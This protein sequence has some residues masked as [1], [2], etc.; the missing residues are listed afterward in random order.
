MTA[1]TQRKTRLTFETADTVRNRPVVVECE[2]YCATVR[3]KG[4]RIRYSI[5]WAS[6][7]YKAA[8]IAADN[9]RAARKTKKGVTQ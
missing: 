7:F 2:P 9:L 6:V 1:L 4:K 3:L 8:E 5:S